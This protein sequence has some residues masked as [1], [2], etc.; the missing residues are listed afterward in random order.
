MS[1]PSIKSQ[2][3]NMQ[4]LNLLTMALVGVVA[5]AVFFY[6]SSRASELSKARSVANNLA[7]SLESSL[8]FLD[9]QSAEK[10]LQSLR[11]DQA[12]VYARY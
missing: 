12:F 6:L 8:L 10:T 5:M 11:F 7:Q 1:K 3:V 9:A 4:M 2:L